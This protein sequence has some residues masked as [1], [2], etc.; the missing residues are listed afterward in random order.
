MEYLRKY[1]AV[2]RDVRN[3]A[4]NM[5]SN[6]SRADKSAVALARKGKFATQGGVGNGSEKTSVED[7]CHW[8]KKADK[9]LYEVK[10]HGKHGLRVFGEKNPAENNLIGELSQVHM[11]LSERNIEQGAYFADFETFKHI[12]RMLVRTDNSQKGL[13]LVQFTLN[14]DLFVEEK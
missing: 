9:A 6:R 7:I 11:I 14:V 3:I 4:G 8:K 10:Q 5:R 1:S 13:T 2:G 12:Y